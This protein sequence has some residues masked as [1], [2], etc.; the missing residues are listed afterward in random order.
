MLQPTRPK[1]ILRLVL[2]AAMSAALFALTACGSDSNSSATATPGGATASAAKLNV[3]ATTVQITALAKEVGAD[4]ITLTGI[5]P[6]GADPHE[7]EP[8]PSDLVA[9]EGAKLILRH[10]IELDSWLDDTLRAGAGATVVTV[11]DG[12]TLAQFEEDGKTVD[13]PHVWHDPDNDKIMV[14]NIAKAL[15][16]ADPASKATYDTNAAAYNQKLDD[17]K[18]QVQAIINE[19]PPRTASS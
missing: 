6:A 16:A 18:T 3:V 4:K 7:F 10:G 8:K 1:L 5:I 14:D 15:D 19:I 17:T 13:D 11:T 12:I 9:I 2:L